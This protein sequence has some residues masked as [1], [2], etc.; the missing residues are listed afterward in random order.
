MQNIFK[1]GITVFLSMLFAM[2]PLYAKSPKDYFDSGYSHHLSGRY[3]SAEKYYT[4]AI[5]KNP[6]YT[7]AYLMRGAVYH[8]RRE[9]QLA[10][11]DY[12]KSIETGADH[13]KA[14]AYYNRGLVL[15]DTGNY[16]AAI[17]DF[18]NALSYSPK[19]ANAYLHRGIAKGRAGNSA[20]QLRDFTTAARLGDFELKKLLQQHAPHLLK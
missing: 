6:S 14:V 19:M 3:E 2:P 8:S 18:S 16:K 1:A 11:N 12:T 15:F 17:K 5:R 10:L 7:Q 20:G 9:Y 4:K 13:F